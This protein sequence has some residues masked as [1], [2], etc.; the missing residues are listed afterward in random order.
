MNNVS[1]N[2]QI[3]IVSLKK[4]LLI[5]FSLILSFS[6]PFILISSDLSIYISAV[7]LISL[8]IF[9]RLMSGKN[10]NVLQMLLYVRKIAYYEITADGLLIKYSNKEHLLDYKKIEHFSDVSP[11][12]ITKTIYNSTTQNFGDY[13][14]SSEYKVYYLFITKTF[15]YTSVLPI[16]IL[17]KEDKKIFAEL[18]NH[19]TFSQFKTPKDTKFCVWGCAL[20]LCILFIIFVILINFF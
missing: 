11:F 3:Y 2:S 6:L 7:L 1:W 14:E 16:F 17:P 12:S 13:A 5:S 18:S 8:P 15:F 19:I 9:L 4:I 20:P 10:E